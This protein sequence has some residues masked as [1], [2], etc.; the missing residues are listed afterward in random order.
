MTILENISSSQKEVLY[1]F[2]RSLV[3][4]RFPKKSMTQK[5]VML[6]TVPSYSLA[7]RSLN[8]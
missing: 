4:L 6:V 7:L 3:L 2:L 1:V 5:A 8:A